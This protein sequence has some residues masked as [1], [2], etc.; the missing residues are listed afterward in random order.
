M[1]SGLLLFTLVEVLAL[2]RAEHELAVTTDVRR[3]QGQGY[4][5]FVEQFFLK[6]L[7]EIF[8][9]GPLIP[10]ELCWSA[11]RCDPFLRSSCIHGLT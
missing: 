10:V 2:R 4:R 5:S 7:A 9:K 1:N 11:L 6:A 8:S 3:G